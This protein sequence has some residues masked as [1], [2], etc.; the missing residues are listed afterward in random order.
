MLVAETNR[1]QRA[2]KVVKKSI[3]ATIRSLKRTL[4]ELEQQTAR[5][6]ENSPA[7]QAKVTMLEQVPGV[8]PQLARTL[9]AEVPELGR[10]GRRQ[11]AALIGVA[12]Y[13]HESGLFKGRRMIWCGRAAV[14]RTLYIAMLS[15]T[16]FNPVLAPF[17]RRLLERGK[18]KKLAYIAC[19]RKLLVILNAMFRDHTTWNPILDFQHS[20]STLCSAAKHPDKRPRQIIH[21]LYFLPSWAWYLYTVAV[22]TRESVSV[23][24]STRCALNPLNRGNSTQPI[25]L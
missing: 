20:R 1:H 9:I 12:P 13:A 16:R 4:A 6:G 7:Q 10:L 21:A 11:L 14:R 8:G 2:T 22:R 17:Y 15:A 18:S 3:V 19:A 24:F 23:P 5:Y 25:Q